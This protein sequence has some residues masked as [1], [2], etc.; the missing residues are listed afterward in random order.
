M[1]IIA[2]YL[3]CVELFVHAAPEARAEG[4]SV[5]DCGCC[6]FQSDEAAVVG[7]GDLPDIDDD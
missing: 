6:E 3:G 4:G 1:G 2:R 7:G 5:A